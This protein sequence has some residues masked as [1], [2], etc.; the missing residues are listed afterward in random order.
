MA[1]NGLGFAILPS[2]AVKDAQHLHRIPLL[3]ENKEPITR[4]TWLVGY[5][6]AFKLKQVRAFMEIVKE[7]IKEQQEKEL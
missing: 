1:L 7:Y 4:D 3:K 6:S 2:I 5:E